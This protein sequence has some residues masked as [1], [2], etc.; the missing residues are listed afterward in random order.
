MRINDFSTHG[1]NI[2]VH[3]YSAFSVSG[4]NIDVTVLL[5]KLHMDGIL[6]FRNLIQFFAFS[7]E[8]YLLVHTE[9]KCK[10]LI[11]THEPRKYPISPQNVY[12]VCIAHHN[13]DWDYSPGILCF[14]HAIATHLTIKYLRL[15]LLV[16][17][18][19]MGCSDFTNMEGHRDN[20]PA[21]SGGLHAP[22]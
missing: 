6:R 7:G 4:W 1:K 15:H 20:S 5:V 10:L 17:D 19:K 13:Y 9:S 3:V 8:Q 16:L 12:R 21:M 18:I 11:S 2:L 22:V 14:S